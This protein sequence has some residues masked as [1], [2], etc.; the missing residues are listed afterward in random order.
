MEQRS[1][2]RE[3]GPCVMVMTTHAERVGGVERASRT[4]VR[5]LVD[6]L[7]PRRVGILSVWAQETAQPCTT[8]YAG[9][10][11]TGRRVL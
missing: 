5:T 7:D 6:L 3:R 10:Q 8:L 4:L 2:E 1:A 9:S 11:R